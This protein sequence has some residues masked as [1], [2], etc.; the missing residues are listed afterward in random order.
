MLKAMRRNVQSLKPILWIVVATFIVAIFAIWGGGSRVDEG[1]PSST[2][3]TV[4]GTKISGDAFVQTLRQRLDDMRRQYQQIDASV[5]QQLN[6]PQ[7]VLEQIVQQNL[8]LQTA[9]DLGL[10]VSKEELRE[11]IK[12][13][14]VFQKDG[15][16][17]GFAQYQQILEYNRIPLA[18][19]EAGLKK[20]VLV[21][22]VIQV[23]TS[24]I[25]V[26][27]D[28]VWEAYRKQNESARIDYL[29]A[30]AAKMEAAPPSAA[31]VAAYFEQNKAKYR[32]PDRR[33]GSY[34]YIRTDD[35]LKE[36]KADDQEIAAYYEQNKEQFRD[37]EQVKVSRIHMPFTA[38]DKDKVLAQ[39]RDVQRRAQADEDFAALAR[40]YS[41]DDKAKDG[42]DWGLYDWKGL[43]A[44]ETE[45]V[46]KLEQGQVSDLLE[47]EAGAAI[48]KVTQKTPER[49]KTPDEVKP[50]VKNMLEFRKA[51]SLAQER[52]ERVVNL[53]KREKS[54]DIAAQK[55][56]LHPAS[57][58]PLKRGEAIP[59]K[60][61]AG[62]IS[63]ALFGLEVGGIS[64][65]LRPPT[66]T[67][68]VE[69]KSVEAERDA[70]LAEVQSQVEADLL[71]AAKKEAAR[72]KVLEARSRLT[73]KWDEVA[74]KTGLEYKSVEEHKREQYLSLI[75]ESPEFDRLAF[76]L[77]L[78]EP[79]EP[80]PAENGYALLRVVDRKTVTREDFEKVKA[81]ERTTLL[82]AERNKFLQSYLAQAQ[83]AKKVRINYE[84]FL[85]LN[86]EILGRYKTE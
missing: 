63:E 33:V 16:F 67:A 11:R 20:D 2:L 83:Q 12:S 79:S 45:A 23:L 29:V 76:S 3:I 22:K 19:F 4:G 25:A 41:K 53:A 84:L 43:S 69:L 75:G 61:M 5:I 54:L 58:G 44:K 66:G 68:A 47:L 14:P 57:T 21:T 70:T 36:V 50:M 24:G 7:Q 74:A 56:G 40:T 31:E 38:D 72:K 59:D 71:A 35:I 18:E 82:E 64:D 80:L 78:K 9:R 55:E 8:L 60:D 1:S 51:Q 46:Q 34:V 17:I 86:T 39:A 52:M 77:P 37:P 10:R 26:T 30:D 65:L 49:I 15:Q 73:D 85:R 32:L 6:V 27:D 42:G 13:Y 28:Q 62:T 81:T 48:L